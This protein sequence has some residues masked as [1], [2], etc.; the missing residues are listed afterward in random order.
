MPSATGFNSSPNRFSLSAETGTVGAGLSANSELFQFRWTSTT[1]TAAIRRIQVSAGGITAFTAG[2]A[3]MDAVV[4]R[5]WTVAGTGGGTATIS[6]NNAKLKTSFA[7]TAVTEIRIATT[8]ALG[9]GTKTLDSQ[10]FANVVG[11]TTATA[12]TSIIFPTIIFDAMCDDQYP[13]LLGANEGF[14]IRAT[15]PATGTWTGGFAVTWDE[16]DG[17]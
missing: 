13:L 1:K 9:A 17:Y 15:V 5:S 6:G 3:K 16:Y 2:F 10:A 4:A 11:S 12:G 14:V 8:A 7:T